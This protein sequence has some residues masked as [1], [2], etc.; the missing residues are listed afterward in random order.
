MVITIR[1]RLEDTVEDSTT[2]PEG[3]I[4]IVTVMMSS[5]GAI[6]IYRPYIM[7]GET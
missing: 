6:I 1:W 2:P 5:N 3:G 4:E 7:E